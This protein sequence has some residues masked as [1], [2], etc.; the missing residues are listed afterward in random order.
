M[1]ELQ[2]VVGFMFAPRFGEEYVLLIGKNRPSWQTGKLNGVG[3]R[4]EP[5]E[6]AELAM[7]REF[8]EEVGIDTTPGNWRLFATLHLRYGTVRFFSANE[9]EAITPTQRT[10]E[11]PHWVNLNAVLRRNVESVHNLRWLLPLA[12]D[13]DGVTVVAHDDSPVPEGQE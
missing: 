11:K 3:G 9:P 10:D 6:S 7:C 13:E 5:G 12:L 4:I 8:R 1:S 2:Y